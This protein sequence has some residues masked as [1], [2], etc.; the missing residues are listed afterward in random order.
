[1]T[2]PTA[3]LLS[4][5]QLDTRFP[6]PAGDVA[7]HDTYVCEVQRIL[8]PGLSVERVVCADI[9][10]DYVKDIEQAMSTARGDVVT[11]SCGFLRPWQERLQALCRVPFLSSSLLALPRLVKRFGS[12]GLAIVTFDAEKLSGPAYRETMAAFDGR[13]IGL[14]RS[15][16]L[17]RVIADDLGELDVA[18]AGKEVFETVGNALRGSDVRALLLE[19]GNLMPYKQRLV[20][21]LGVEV[22]DI[23]TLT[24][25]TNPNMVAARFQ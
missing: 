20:Q 22:F 21:E 3:P 8:V 19:C 2:A 18:L 14:E 25:E 1:M 16:H 9:R 5:I 4:I 7:S 13:V 23:L 15:S 6:R 12:D 10:E 17:Y 24:H 11:T